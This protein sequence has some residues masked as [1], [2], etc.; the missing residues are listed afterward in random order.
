MREN[1]PFGMLSSDE[2]FIPRERCEGRRE[3]N[4]IEQMFLSISRAAVFGFEHGEHGK[5]NFEHESESGELKE[6]MFQNLHGK[7]GAY[8]GKN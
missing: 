7:E 3:D 4:F 5:N 6:Q 1:D 8:G 2:R